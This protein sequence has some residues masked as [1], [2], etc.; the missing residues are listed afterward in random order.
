MAENEY[1]IVNKADFEKIGN[2]VRASN[3]TTDKYSISEL[4]DAVANSIVPPTNE[5]Y[6]MLTTNASGNTQWVD[7]LAYPLDNAT[8][9]IDSGNGMKIVMITKDL[10]TLEQLQNGTFTFWFCKELSNG[11]KEE[12]SY[13]GVTASAMDENNVLWIF[14]GAVGEESRDF[15]FACLEDNFT[16][17]GLTIPEKGVYVMYYEEPDGG[18]KQMATRLSQEPS[19]TKAYVSG[20]AFGEKSTPDYTWDG[21]FVENKK[22]ET[23]YLPDVVLNQINQLSGEVSSMWD[24]INSAQSTADSALTNANSASDEVRSVRTA[25]SE[26]KTTANNAQTTA[27][28]A[29]TT[30]QSALSMLPTVTST[31]SG[32]FLRVSSTGKWVAEA[33]ASAEGA[34][35]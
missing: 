34:S 19:Y 1:V 14:S 21:V 28:K 22:L 16:F 10:P 30:A 33:I 13:S 17:Q 32:K 3:G 7:R 31:D 2:A 11:T 23:K 8:T 12:N 35:F 25:V 24:S 18:G 20:V 26:V 27:N 29:Q 6:K 15:G 4:A 5:A 9:Y